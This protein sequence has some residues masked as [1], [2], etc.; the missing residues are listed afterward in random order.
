MERFK[1]QLQLPGFTS[2]SQ[3][4]L[5]QARVLV[6]GAGGLGC[7]AL[8]HLASAGVGFITIADFDTIDESNLSRQWLFGPEDIGKSKA[9]VAERV[10]TQKFPD[11][12]IEVEDRGVL[13]ANILELVRRHDVVV[14]CTDSI[15]MRYMLND[16]CELLDKPWV[17][18]GVFQYEGQ[19]SVFNYSASKG[20]SGNYRDVFPFQEG[21]A[22]VVDCNAA[23][24]LCTL[25]GILGTWQANEVIKIITGIGQV[26]SN[27]L[28]VYNI[29]NAESSHL[30]FERGLRPDLNMPATDEDFRLYNYQVNCMNDLNKE[31]T[32]RAAMDKMLAGEKLMWVDVRESHE[33][34]KF[35]GIQVHSFPLSVIESYAP[36]L[37]LHVK[38]VCF[39]Q[40]G[41]RSLKAIE[42]LNMV[43]PELDLYSL[44]GGVLAW[45]AFRHN[46][47]DLSE[48]M[49]RIQPDSAN[50]H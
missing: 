7:P 1:R 50:S 41:V 22:P 45:E 44:Q 10:L 17:Y 39:C 31:I 47:V 2:E 34:P 26:S 38:I 5:K 30:L 32:C 37:P 15:S 19:L 13:Q 23:G 20:Q 49:G 27:R 16:A 25:T 8:I 42:R 6:V 33:I 4:K 35:E 9:L 28:M 14:D 21:N 36:L 11:I 12:Q 43:R 29:F 24:V 40:S 48:I 46:Q 18:A 3:L